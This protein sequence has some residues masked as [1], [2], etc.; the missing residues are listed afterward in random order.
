M[1]SFHS[2]DL[3]LPHWFCSDRTSA[4]ISMVIANHRHTLGELTFVF[5]SD[6]ALLEINRIHLNHDYFTDIITFDLSGVR[7][8]VRGE[9]YIS[10]ER[11]E[12]N[13]KELGKTIDNE[14]NR[15]II[16][17]VLHLLG[18]TDDTPEGKEQMRREEDNCLSL[19]P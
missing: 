2:L 9:I 3:D 17:G 19:L 18:Y 12:E 16:H 14:L 1:I 13:A 10:L 15:V 11:V 8:L 7:G 4:W 5:C 6:R